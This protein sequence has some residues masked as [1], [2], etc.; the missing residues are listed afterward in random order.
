MD[1]LRFKRAASGVCLVWASPIGLTTNDKQIRALY[2]LARF[3]YHWDNHN[4][5]EIFIRIIT[6]LIMTS[7]DYLTVLAIIKIIAT[8]ATSR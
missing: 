5:Y 4:N 3:D 7:Q 8:I 1:S 2:L 6:I